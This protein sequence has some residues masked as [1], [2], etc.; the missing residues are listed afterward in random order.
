MEGYRKV[1]DYYKIMGV[2]PSAS[3]EEIKSQYKYLAFIYH[4]DR[5]DDPKLKIQA[6]EDLRNINEAYDVLSDPQKRRK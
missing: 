5:L 2:N 1:K 4:P 3:P 6:G